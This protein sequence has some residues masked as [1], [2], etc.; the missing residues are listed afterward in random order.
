MFNFLAFLGF[1]PGGEK[2]IFSTK[3]LIEVFD[4]E[5]IQKSGARFNDEKLDWTNKEHIKTLSHEDK[6]A[7]V[8]NFIP[9]SIKQAKYYSTDII[10]RAL[11]VLTERISKWGDITEMIESKELDWVFTDIIID[12]SKLAWKNSTLED[13]K[14]YLAEVVSLL[15]TIDEKNWNKEYIKDVIWPLTD[16]Y[17]RGDVLWPLRFCLT[18]M[19]K[20]P[21]P[22]TVMEIIGKE[23]SLERVKKML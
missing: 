22:F 6:L 16:Q 13:S 19:E 8:L 10:S 18:G 11:D 15:E 21:E 9:E 4:I 20:S 12:E 5:R 23:R 14:I 17:G 3:E 7:S 2:E 1:N